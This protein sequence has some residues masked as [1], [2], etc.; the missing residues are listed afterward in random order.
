MN[1]KD[2]KYWAGI[3]DKEWR[4][5]GV[6]NFEHHNVFVFFPGVV[7]NGRAEFRTANIFGCVQFEAKA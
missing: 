5:F 1:C 2:C 4:T 3:D 6:C 7:P